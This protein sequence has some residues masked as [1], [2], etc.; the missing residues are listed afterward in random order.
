MKTIQIFKNIFNVG[1][2]R[3]EE[4]MCFFSLKFHLLLFI[5][6]GDFLK[7]IANMN[8]CLHPG[9]PI[10]KKLEWVF[11]PVVFYMGF[12]ATFVCTSQQSFLQYTTPTRQDAP[13][14]SPSSYASFLS[15][16][17]PVMSVRRSK[18]SP[19]IGPLDYTIQNS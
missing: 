2:N 16:M 7:V 9:L 14:V 18:V 4:R 1:S 19:V 6:I 17:L 11:I 15:V 3:S 10:K 12:C 5:Y 13:S 8:P